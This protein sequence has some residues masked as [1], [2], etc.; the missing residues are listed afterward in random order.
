MRL[1]SRYGSVVS[2]R[3][4]TLALVILLAAGVAARADEGADRGAVVLA[5]NE[6][7]LDAVREERLGTPVA[8]RLYAMVNIAIYDAVNGIDRA[9]LG[10]FDRFFGRDFALVEPVGAPRRGNREAAAAAAAHAVLV[11]LVP[12][13]AGDFDVQLA[14]DLAR[15]GAGG[16]VV[17]GQLW[18]ERVGEA[19]VEL[20]ENDG[21]APQQVLPGGTAPGQFRRDF[22][23]AQFAELLPFGIASSLPYESDG[24]PALD[25][26]AYAGAL[27]EVQLLGNGNL[28]NAAFD[29]IFRFW[30][31]GGGSAQPPG[32]WIKVA[33]V[34]AEQEETTDSI[35]DSARLFALLGMALGDAVLPAWSNKVNFQ[36]W[37]PGTA[38]VEADSDG[39]PLTLADP[40]WV[41]RNGSLGSSPEHSSGQSTFAGAGATIL[42]GFYCTDFIAFSFEGDDAIAGPRSFAS[43]SAA[44]FE[45]GRARILAGIHFEFSNQAGQTAGRG[46]ANEILTTRLQRLRPPF[47]RKPRCP[48]S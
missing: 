35:S 26:L 43:F 21:A 6:Q 2:G 41:P 25:S 19:V 47:D 12:E 20:R 4:S 37:R 42:A 22:T 11:A 17:A 24:P 15:L 14:A 36:F 28:P 10:H 1:I 31:G 44:A 45:A 48:Q 40:G 29:E 3:A 18:G 16:Q 5:W 8:A 46:L 13:R 33:A 30:R 27:A 38:I 23:S 7:A 32:E 9:R 34:V 39:N